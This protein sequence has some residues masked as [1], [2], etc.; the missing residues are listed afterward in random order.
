MKDD[1]Y[2]ES[3]DKRTKEYKDWKDNHDKSIKGLGDVV[4]KVT[5]A[6][7]IKK[8][9]KKVFG[10]DCGCNERKQKLNQIFSFKPVECFTE[11]QF[12]QWTQFRNRPNKDKLTAED[13]DFVI[14]M[15]E[16]LFKRTTKSCSTCG[17]IIIKFMQTIDKYYESY[18]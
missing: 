15:M 1:S 12:N 18:L 17:G 5:E 8:V 9:V 13:Q 14:K 3:L 6:T 4:E 11:K 2:Y 16:N 10:D 7:G